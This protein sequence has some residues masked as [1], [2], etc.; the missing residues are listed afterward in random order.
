MPLHVMT[1]Q[2]KPPS[3][4]PHTATSHPAI[5]RAYDQMFTF[6]AMKRNAPALRP[7]LLRLNIW[8]VI[9]FHAKQLSAVHTEI[10]RDARGTS[11]LS[12]L[13]AKRIAAATTAPPT[14]ARV[15]H[16]LKRR[17]TFG[18]FHVRFAIGRKGPDTKRPTTRY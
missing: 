14:F 11:E 13:I 16:W 15:I 8:C 17:L 1:L 10:D 4:E 2:Q 6:L 7:G 18:F 3:V 5:Q 9:A 12:A